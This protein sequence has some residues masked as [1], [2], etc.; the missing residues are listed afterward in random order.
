MTKILITGCTGN[1]GTAV[2]EV[3]SKSHTD[4]QITGGV[5]DVVKNKLLEI[6]YNMSLV[7]LDFEKPETY[8]NTLQNYDVIFLLRPPQIDNIEAYFKPFIESSKTAKVKLIIFLS[9]QGADKNNL[10]IQQSEIPFV[11]LRPSYF[12]QNFLNSLNKDLVEQNRIYL[13]AGKA[14][15]NL[16]DVGDIGTATNHILQNTNKYLNQSFEITSND[17]LTFGEMADKLTTKLN[18]KIT[19][20]S[21]NLISFIV[22]KTKEKVP[23]KMILVIIMLHFLPRFSKPTLLSQDFKKIT[24]IEP[25]FF[26]QFIE[27]NKDSLM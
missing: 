14:K 27:N 1:V 13:P 20:K 4:L 24:G 18:K 11:F 5:R 9:V 6:K 25:T 7:N 3:L 17:Q 10:I 21:P 26:E 19:Y 12:M 8:K 23:F 16:V 2:L 15:F 22:D